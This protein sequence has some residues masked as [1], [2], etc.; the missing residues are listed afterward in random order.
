[1]MAGAAAM[2]RVIDGPVAVRAVGVP[3]S[4]TLRVMVKVPAQEEFGVPVIEAPDAEFT[5]VRHVG[6]V[7][8]AKLQV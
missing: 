7:P 5:R 1:M 2:I 8:L 6:S 4:V 3:E